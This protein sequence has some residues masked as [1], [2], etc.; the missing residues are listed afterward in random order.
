MSPV[1][2]AFFLGAVVW[3]PMGVFLMALLVAGARGDIERETVNREMRA[4]EKG[5]K[6]GVDSLWCR[7]EG[8]LRKREGPKDA[9]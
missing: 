9:A 5:R 3:C 1:W 8:D 7:M 4:F 2:V 6:A